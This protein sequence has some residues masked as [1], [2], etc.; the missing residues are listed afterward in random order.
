MQEGDKYKK[1]V[2]AN[3]VMNI[4][5]T[6][7]GHPVQISPQQNKK[8]EPAKKPLKRRNPKKKSSRKRHQTQPHQVLSKMTGPLKVALG[9]L[10]T[11]LPILGMTPEVKVNQDDVLMDAEIDRHQPVGA[12]SKGDTEAILQANEEGQIRGYSVGVTSGAVDKELQETK[13]NKIGKPIPGDQGPRVN[14]LR[15]KV[16]TIVVKDISKI[17]TVTRSQNPHQGTA[18]PKIVVQETQAI[19]L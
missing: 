10:Q 18:I 15:A 14:D 4:A 2:T 6:R 3:I 11:L 12:P 8:V 16:V 1:S 7:K 5:R 17:E 9:P 13:A 19:N